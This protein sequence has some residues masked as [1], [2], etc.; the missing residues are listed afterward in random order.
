MKDRLSDYEVEKQLSKSDSFLIND[1]QKPES[2]NFDE[3]ISM[4][5]NCIKCPPKDLNNFSAINQKLKHIFHLSHTQNIDANCISK[6]LKASSLFAEKLN[7]MIFEDTTFLNNNINEMLAFLNNIYDIHSQSSTKF[8][9]SQVYALLKLYNSMLPTITINVKDDKTS[10]ML[11]TCLKNICTMVKWQNSTD[12][13]FDLVFDLCIK[14]SNDSLIHK[15]YRYII[16]LVAAVKF[17]LFKDPRKLLEIFFS[18][19]E[20][21]QTIKIKNK[22]DISISSF[23]ITKITQEFMNVEMEESIDVIIN[24]S[25][26]ILEILNEFLSN[27]VFSTRFTKLNVNKTV[28]KFTSDSLILAKFAKYPSSIYS[29]LSLYNMSTKIISRHD[30]NHCLITSFIEVFSTVVL[31][32]VK[33]APNVETSKLENRVFDDITVIFSYFKNHQKNK[34]F[35]LIMVYI[36]RILFLTNKLN[37][38]SELQGLIYETSKK[39][40]KN[41]NINDQISSN[42]DFQR[43]NIFYQVS[44]LQRYKIDDSYSYFVDLMKNNVI[45]IRLKCLKCLCNITKRST[46]YVDKFR[47][48]QSVKERIF[49]RSFSVRSSAIDILACLVKF[50]H[51]KSQ[52]CLDILFK[53]MLDSSLPVRKRVM[54]NLNNIL[55]TPN[56]TINYDE[57]ILKLTKRIEDA[58]HIKNI[59][60]KSVINY[61]KI[62]SPNDISKVTSSIIFVWQQL[63][64]DSEIL[65]RIFDTIDKKISQKDKYAFFLGLKKVA[66]HIF[67]MFISGI[68]RGDSQCLEY[69]KTLYIYSKIFP[70]Y[71]GDYFPF[72][73]DILTSLNIDSDVFDGIFQNVCKIFSNLY[74][75]QSIPD[76]TIKMLQEKFINII[77]KNSS[78]LNDY[79]YCLK[80]LFQKR[81]ENFRM[82][83]DLFRNYVKFLEDEINGSNYANISRVLYTISAIIKNFSIEVLITGERNLIASIKGLGGIFLKYCTSKDSDTKL[84]AYMCLTNFLQQY[85]KY[86]LDMY[87]KRAL[88]VCLNSTSDESLKICVIKSFTMLLK[89]EDSRNEKLN[90]ESL[91]NKYSLISNVIQTYFAVLQQGYFTKNDVV[92][93]NIMIIV[94]LC[95][96]LGFMPPQKY[97]LLIIAMIMDP[98]ADIEK[99]ALYLIKMIRKKYPGTIETNIKQ[100]IKF[101]FCAYREMLNEDAFQYYVKN[102]NSLFGPLYV[103]TKFYNQRKK[104]IISFIEYLN[105][106][107]QN[108][109]FILFCGL[110]LAYL[111]FKSVKEILYVLMKLEISLGLID[112]VKLDDKDN[113]ENDDDSAIVFKKIIL[114][115]MRHYLLNAY[116]LQQEQISFESPSS[117]L[118]S[119]NIPERKA[120]IFIDFL[121]YRRFKTNSK[122]F[123]RSKFYKSLAKEV[124]FFMIKA[125]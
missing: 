27:L 94:R 75:N 47:I 35:S 84:K 106:E 32:Y 64:D 49:D 65:F 39:C 63:A 3:V 52:K 98:I 99:S 30:I 107:D 71:C 86:Y 31:F 12:E 40:R 74:S 115:K 83:V 19:I 13:L 67:K 46:N 43:I 111:P 118:K 77:L 4:I 97:I 90:D 48:Y 117:N 108:I 91:K 56:L 1:S 17:K 21:S 20:C 60:L 55:Q 53:R 24:I 5:L 44:L 120:K 95:I 9:L 25:K 114:L 54:S 66:D 34:G 72:F 76:E 8:S 22:Y 62:E 123:N 7:V 38:N 104:F 2:K 100:S 88:D 73:T 6:L 121:F 11:T 28:E 26:I 45:S 23:L 89:S 116:N 14:L 113:L 102:T 68:S 78:S 69:S 41:L 51:K 125:E 124:S 50:D 93:R 112:E 92:R 87:Y 42:S 10:I 29:I 81:P 36:C 80:M 15:S 61:W 96:K 79:I 110:S 37:L 58:S 16:K 105:A 109:H 103:Q 82:I 59:V 85:P 57:I 101:S 18:F 119:S 33:H 122:Q 70:S